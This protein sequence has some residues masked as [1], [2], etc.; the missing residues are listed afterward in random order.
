[1]T[2]KDDQGQSES[3][4]V[5]LRFR[6]VFG[7]GSSRSSDARKRSKREPGSTSP[8]GGGRDPEGLGSVVD[9]LTARLGWNSPLAQ[10]ELLASWKDVA[11]VETAEHSTPVG[12]EDGVL[13]VRCDS[14]AWATQLRLMRVHIT[15]QIASR[16][17]DAGIEQVRFEGPNAPSWKRGPR[18]IPG[19]GPRDTYG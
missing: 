7:D 17:P 6:Q 18:S 8:F 14:T 2:E 3:T 5:Y 15:S 1:M 11:G 4:G 10:S 9:A 16:Y 12:I 19:R 13:T